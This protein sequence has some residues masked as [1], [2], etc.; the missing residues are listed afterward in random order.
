MFGFSL[1]LGAI[2]STLGGLIGGA[3]FK[4]EAPVPPA[5]SGG[6]PGV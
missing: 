6:T 3:A 4:V 1:I 2:F 5:S